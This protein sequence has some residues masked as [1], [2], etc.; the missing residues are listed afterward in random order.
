MSGA[1]VSTPLGDMAPLSEA[2]IAAAGSEAWATRADHRHPRLT[3]ATNGTLNASGEATVNFTR[4][5]T[6]KPSVAIL[7]SETADGQP[8]VFKVK[9]WLGVGG[10]TWTSGDYTGCVIK[11]YRSQT[12][13][14]NLATLLLGGVFNLFAGS[15]SGA[16]YS[17]IA[18]QAS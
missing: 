12:V 6:T 4:T 8:I 2:G 18:V 11:G 15:A 9:T 1:S 7:Y 13:P 16:E 14:Q 10:T 17:L 3:S 5:F